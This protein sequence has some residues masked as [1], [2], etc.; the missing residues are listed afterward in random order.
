[1][2]HPKYGV[3]IPMEC[4]YIINTNYERIPMVDQIYLI[5]RVVLLQSS[6][7]GY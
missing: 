6:L 5:N 1:M 7:S 4:V 2:M 3:R